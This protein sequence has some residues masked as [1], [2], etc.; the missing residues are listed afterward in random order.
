MKLLRIPANIGWL[1]AMNM[2]VFTTGAATAQ[3]PAGSTS[4]ATGTINNGQTTCIT[5]GVSSGVTLNN[6]ARMVI[7]S[8]GNYTGNLSTNNGSAIEVQ[9]GGQFTPNQANS[10]SASL[11]NN[12]TV[13]I[14]N[15]SLSTG[16]SFT[17]NGTFNWN[18]NWNQGSVT[19]TVTN[20]ACGTM[21]FA[22]GTTVSN[23]STINNQGV[24]NLAQG[25]GINNGSRVT[26]RGRVDVG[27]DLNLSGTLYNENIAVFRGSNNNISSNNTYDS[28]VNTGKIVITGGATS[29]IRT[30][31]DGLFKVN[32]SYTINGSTFN[33]N[34][35]TA[36]LRI[37]GSFSNNGMLTGNGSLYVVAG[38]GNNQ[39][40]AGYSGA[41]Q[42]TVNKNSGDFTGTQSNLVYNTGLAAIDT[43]SYNP[44]LD[45]AASCTVLPIRLSTLQAVYNNGRVQ[46]NWQAYTQ[47]DVRSFT[48][49]YS[50]DGKSFTEAGNL[51][52][53]GINNQTTPYVYAHSPAVNGTL[54]Y[55]VRGTT[56]DGSVY[57]SNMVTVKTG[58]TFLAN[59]EVFPIPFK[60]ILL[61]SMQ[62]EKTGMIQVALYDA[63]GRLVRRSQQTG[64]VGR[65]TIAIGD[66][67][68]LLPGVYLLQVKAGEH[69][70]TQKLTK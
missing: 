47:S 64:L 29:S 7:I 60:D 59:T 10:F 30:R 70:A 2:V 32:G 17:N 45:N 66:L 44:P 25:L 42:L 62:L 58:N 14:N 27:G 52:A 33:I 18:S 4:N 11:T 40:I 22:Q 57:Y 46:L 13:T 5:T 1:L 6:G 8:G 20:N 24:L 49:E 38:I 67:S 63:S 48:I 16:A 68:A 19:L 34:N 36:Q 53:A 50:Q 41:Q 55:R 28:L 26:N 23:N 15:I 54:Y 61:I 37:G 9:A 31:N 35:S 56:V 51:A 39:T 12:G 3:C 65:N 21:N 69:I 43:G